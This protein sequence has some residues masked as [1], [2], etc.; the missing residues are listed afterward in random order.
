MSA[1]IVLLWCPSPVYFW[2]SCHADRTRLMAESR[3]AVSRASRATLHAAGIEAVPSGNMLG[4]DPRTI[5]KVEEAR[6][7]QIEKEMAACTF[8]PQIRPL[9]GVA[10]KV[11]PVR[12]PHLIPITL[13]SWLDFQFLY[14]FLPR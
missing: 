4:K 9:P 2:R 8:S 7:E 3:R 12:L 13:L 10:K 11:C 14:W 6:L 5:Q 1:A